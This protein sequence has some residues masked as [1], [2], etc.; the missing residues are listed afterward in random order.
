MIAQAD[1]AAILHALDAGFAAFRAAFVAALA[2]NPGGQNA[3]VEK[4][5]AQ[6][7]TPAVSRKGKGGRP[8]KHFADRDHA[9]TGA[10]RAKFSRERAKLNRQVSHGV[11]QH[12]LSLED[13][14]S[15]HLERDLGIGGLGERDRAKLKTEVS[16]HRVSQ[17][18]AIPLPA[19][20]QPSEANARL[21]NEKLGAIDA[22]NCLAK[23][24]NHHE[25]SGLRLSL[26]GWQA[27]YR[28]WVLS[29]RT[30]GAQRSLPLVASIPPGLDPAQRD[31]W[32]GGWR[33]GMPTSE[34]MR[35]R[36]SSQFYARF[37]S[38]ELDAWQAYRTRTEGKTYATGRD[39]GRWFESQWPPGHDVR[40][41]S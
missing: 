25:V 36:A 2:P 13:N 41:A 19:N 1:P 16:Q 8:R 38:A 26:A 31:D 39:G 17:Q 20:W 4:P 5:I 14:N 15:K 35:K 6:P 40:Q 10:E 32:R 12:S 24:R 30:T 37:G 21:A 11:S 28:N 29:E 22:A 23:F 33:P 34:E 9:A 27:R 18:A 3:Q 7:L